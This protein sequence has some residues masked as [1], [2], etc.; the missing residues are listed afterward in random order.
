MKMQSTGIVILAAGN[1]SRMGRP[2]QLLPFN[3]STLIRRITAEAVKVSDHAVAVVLGACQEV[4]APEIKEFD[5]LTVVNEEWQQGMGKSISVGLKALTDKHPAITRVILVVADQPYVTAELFEKMIRQQLSSGKGMIACAYDGIT[6]TPVL[7]SHKYFQAL[8]NLGGEAGAR[9]I[10][11]QHP[12]DV[13]VVTFEAGAID[14]DTLAD[15]KNVTHQPQE[16]NL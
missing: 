13:D 11:Q 5:I 14:I 3:G 10:V 6:G 16:N 12:A 8:L 4:I 15:Y 1:S 2:K 7:F 9:K